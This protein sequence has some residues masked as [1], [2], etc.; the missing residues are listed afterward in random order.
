MIFCE[1]ATSAQEAD[2][3]KT[4]LCSDAKIVQTLLTVGRADPTVASL[5]QSTPLHDACEEP[6]PEIIQLIVHVSVAGPYD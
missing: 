6:S 2:Q 5:T 3:E 4:T 1:Q